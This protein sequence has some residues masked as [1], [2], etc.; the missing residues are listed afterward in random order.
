MTVGYLPASPYLKLCK[1]PLGNSQ[2]KEITEYAKYAV[3]MLIPEETAAYGSLK[4]NIFDGIFLGNK[5]VSEITQKKY[6]SCPAEQIVQLMYCEFLSRLCGGRSLFIYSFDEKRDYL[7]I[8]PRK[9]SARLT[10]GSKSSSGI[11]RRLSAT[12]KFRFYDKYLYEK[13]LLRQNELELK[14]GGALMN[15][16]EKDLAFVTRFNEETYFKSTNLTQYTE[17]RLG[18]KEK[19][20]IL[21]FT[22][23]YSVSFFGLSYNEI[24]TVEDVFGFSDSGIRSKDGIKTNAALA[25]KNDLQRCTDAQLGSMLEQMGQA[26]CRIPLPRIYSDIGARL[27]LNYVLFNAVSKTGETFLQLT[28]SELEPVRIYKK[29]Y[30]A[31]FK[32]AEERAKLLSEY[33]EAADMCVE[34]KELLNSLG[35]VV[36]DAKHYVKTL[37]LEKKVK[38]EEERIV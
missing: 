14:I 15:Q 3:K 31:S 5:S 16:A 2:Y 37:E 20:D 17:K 38:E 7:L 29:R 33:K 27:A 4:L 11:Q 32:Q 23:L 22:V 26:L 13:A 6:S 36:S 28:N 9:I 24:F 35:A 34:L 8:S 10:E 21:A 19:S 25:L 18:L 1:K 12:E 30:E